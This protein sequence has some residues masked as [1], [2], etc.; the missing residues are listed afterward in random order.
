MFVHDVIFL[1]FSPRSLFFQPCSPVSPF[2]PAAPRL[3]P[4][5]A[6][7]LRWWPARWSPL[8]ACPPWPPPLGPPRPL[9]TRHQ[10]ST[11]RESLERSVSARSSS[12]SPTA[13]SAAS[14]VRLSQRCLPSRHAAAPESPSRPALVPLVRA[15]FED[16]GYKLVA[17]KMLTPT[18]AQAEDNY[19]G[20]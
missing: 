11:W 3:S 13:S 6:P 7:R 16:K 4:S 1:H 19:A 10:P 15:Q 8:P 14:S 2:S 20:L 18:L 17:L 9:A 5:S 12:S